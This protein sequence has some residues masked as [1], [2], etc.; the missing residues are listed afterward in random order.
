MSVATGAR[1]ETVIDGDT[2]SDKGAVVHLWGIDA[3]DTRHSIKTAGNQTPP[4]ALSHSCVLYR[5]AVASFP[6][7]SRP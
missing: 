2:L 6:F 7:T 5:G 3:P 4:T 1:A